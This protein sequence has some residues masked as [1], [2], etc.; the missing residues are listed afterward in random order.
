MLFF[1]RINC[2]IWGH[3]WLRQNCSIQRC[4]VSCLRIPVRCFRVLL[5][6]VKQSSSGQQQR[7]AT[8]NRISISLSTMNNCITVWQ[9]SWARGDTLNVRVCERE[10]NNRVRTVSVYVSAAEKTSKNICSRV[11]KKRIWNLLENLSATREKLL[12]YFNAITVI[13]ST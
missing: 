2:N 9:T 1:V 12:K 7:A 13:P 8:P 6:A 11:K 3:H 5:S 10:K 4:F